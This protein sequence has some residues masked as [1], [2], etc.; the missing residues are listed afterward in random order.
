MRRC[1]FLTLDEVG[2]F[3]ID[4]ELAY[5]P[6]RAIGWEVEAVSWRRG[7][8]WWHGFDAVLIRSPWDYQ[9]DPRAFLDVLARIEESG[10]SLFNR[11]D[12]VRWNL[13][14]TYLRDLADR[15]VSTTPTEWRDRLEPGQVLQLF[16]ALQ[17][18]EI[19][20]KPVVSANA[21]GAFRLN[22]R[23]AAERLAEI[24]SYY[25][26][27]PLIAQPFARAVLDEG[28]YS[29]I[30]FGGEFSH[31]ILKTPKD[32]DFRVQEEHGGLIRA[33]RPD[34]VLLASARA[35]VRAAGPPQLYAR[36]D[37]VRANDGDGWWLMELELIEPS[38]YLRMDPRAPHRFAE[39]FRAAMSGNSP[40][41]GVEA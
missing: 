22:R 31:C 12:L 18:D 30:F 4:D 40:G 13:R 10:V 9:D 1:A 2:D 19:V 41:N 35:A 38:L 3:V 20:L 33:V 15:G 6:F 32:G 39:A 26:D 24:E 17:A 7:A 23:A 29:L 8:G 37:L 28:E 5:E 11:L 27:H 34:A 21:D 16:D 14:K 25:R 36:V